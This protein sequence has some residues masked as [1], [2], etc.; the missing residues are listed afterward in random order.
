M[1]ATRTGVSKMPAP[2]TMPTVIIVA[3]KMLS[4][5]VGASRTEGSRVA[6]TAGS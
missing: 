1:L 6:A 3:S 2:I 4:V 5:G